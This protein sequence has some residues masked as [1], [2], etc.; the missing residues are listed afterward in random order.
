MF[1]LILA[2]MIRRTAMRHLCYNIGMNMRKITYLS[3]AGVMVELDEHKILI[4]TLCNSA[5]PLYKNPPA[6]LREEI[7]AGMAPFNNI[8]ILL[9]THHHSDHFD[10]E[11]TALFLKQHQNTVVISSPEVITGLKDQ[12]SQLENGRLIRQDIPFGGTGS[13]QIPGLTIQSLAMQHDG[14]EYQDV[15]NLAYLIE[16]AGKKIFHLGDAKPI[17]ENYLHFNLIAQN[18]DL[19]LAPFPYIGLPSSRQLIEKY[20]QPQKIAAIHLPVRELDHQGWINSTV[21]SYLKVKAD[22]IETVFLEEPG[23]V[24]N[25]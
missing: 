12:F 21:K 8:E 9:F 19:L 7:I 2:G 10:P 4:D 1:K 25:L 3:N 15:L 6:E 14:K 18:I 16:A 24:L 13:F 5:L 20:I 17:A 11:S 23:A 22:F